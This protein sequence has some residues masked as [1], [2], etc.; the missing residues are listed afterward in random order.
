MTNTTTP[1]PDLRNATTLTELEDGLWAWLNRAREVGIEDVPNNL[2]ADV[3]LAALFTDRPLK[4][5]RNLR[6]C[7][8]TV[9][10]VEHLGERTYD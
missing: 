4:G 8:I 6:R 5:R 9:V 7:P 10:G 2:T 3:W 1:L